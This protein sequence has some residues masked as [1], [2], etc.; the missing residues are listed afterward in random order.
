MPYASSPEVAEEIEDLG[1]R[2]RRLR[3]GSYSAMDRKYDSARAMA[4]REQKQAYIE[5]M[6]R[7]KK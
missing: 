2:A 1:A 3:Q 6:R 4:G 5:K 7:T